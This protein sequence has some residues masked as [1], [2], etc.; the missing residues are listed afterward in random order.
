MTE[1]EEMTRRVTMDD[2]R[3]ALEEGSGVDEGVN[4][5]RD[6]KTRAFSDLGY[7]SLAV[8]ETGLR[9]GRENDIEIDDS[10]FTDLE[11]PQQLL[12]AVNH[13]LERQAAAS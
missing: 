10:V 2:L 5:D 9:L 4:L 7:D 1:G 13:A 6:L 8:L 3:R 12:D 11:T